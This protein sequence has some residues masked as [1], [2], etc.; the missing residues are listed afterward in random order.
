MPLC[1]IILLTQSH[2]PANQHQFLD[3]I[4][5]FVSSKNWCLLAGK[6]LHVSKNILQSG[7]FFFIIFMQ[8]FYILSTIGLVHWVE[9]IARFRRIVALE[10]SPYIYNTR[11]SKWNYNIR[12]LNYRPFQKCNW[13]FFNQTL[14]L[15]SYKHY[16]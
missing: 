8:Y 3:D 13:T 10:A 2:M 7:N 1:K 14:E 16:Y 11:Y 9:P 4:F 6:W 15:R 5:I 12:W